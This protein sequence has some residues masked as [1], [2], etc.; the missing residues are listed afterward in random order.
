MRTPAHLNS[1]DVHNDTRNRNRALAT[2]CVLNS[3]YCESVIVGCPF[4]FGITKVDFES[5][6]ILVDHRRDSDLYSLS[7][8]LEFAD[9]HDF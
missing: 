8:V 5:T 4:V 1:S 3:N 7:R 6:T 2:V 9:T